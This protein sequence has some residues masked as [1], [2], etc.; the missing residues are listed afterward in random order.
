[1]LTNLLQPRL[2]IQEVSHVILKISSFTSICC[3]VRR[4][5]AISSRRSST[6]MRLCVS[7][8]LKRHSQARVRIK[9]SPSASIAVSSFRACKL[10]GI[11]FAQGLVIPV[12]M[13]RCIHSKMISRKSAAQASREKR[14]RPWSSRRA[15]FGQMIRLATI[16]Q[17]MPIIM[18]RYNSQTVSGFT[19][20]R[21]SRSMVSIAIASFFPIGSIVC[22]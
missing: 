15:E 5:S 18:S 13:Q 2:L 10:L 20:S 16:A 11:D 6:L 3:N 12:S 8:G 22:M 21:D 7:A 19:A 4:R 1:M 9:T 14:I 17:I